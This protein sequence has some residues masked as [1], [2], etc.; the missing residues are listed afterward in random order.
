MNLYL[1]IETI[2]LSEKDL[3]QLK[4]SYEDV[5]PK[6]QT[7]DDYVR[8]TALSGDWGRIFCIGYALDNFQAQV[9][10]QREEDML[11]KFWDIAK[12]ADMFVG[13]FILHFDLPF[14]YRRTTAL[15]IEP[16][17]WLTPE[18]RNRMVHDTRDI[19]KRSLTH[20]NMSASLNFI[21]K[22]FN[23]P[24]PKEKMRGREVWDYYRKGMHDEIIEYCKLDVETTREIYRRLP[25]PTTHAVSN[26][27]PR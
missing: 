7:F 10:C 19:W 5:R 13:H 18:K 17:V 25:T 1:D 3:W 23:L 24:S 26:S 4:E 15:K 12:D 20:K 16:T 27:L 6:D 22:Y 14:I 8:M 9:L 21:A 2:P 11:V